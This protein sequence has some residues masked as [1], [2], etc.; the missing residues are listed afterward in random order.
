MT[1]A[2]LPRLSTPTTRPNGLFQYLADI[3]DGVIEARTIAARYDHLAR[4]SP[5]ELAHLGLDRTDIAH[6]AV[7]GVKGL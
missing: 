2:A 1:T 4:M 7:F 5:S 3:V 6:A